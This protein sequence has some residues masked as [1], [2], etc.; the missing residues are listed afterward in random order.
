[1]DSNFTEVKAKI[2]KI[3]DTSMHLT[4][5]F[6]DEHCANCSSLCNKKD[7]VTKIKKMDGY[8]VG[9]TVV[10]KNTDKDIMMKA[11]VIYFIPVLSILVV[12]MVSKYLLMF[13][14]II[15]AILSLVSVP[16]L[17]II[18]KQVYK[19]RVHIDIRKV[20]ENTVTNCNL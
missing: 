15:S 9:D 12:S 10:I 8:N 4:K 1:M 20:D 18:I 3:D 2:I 11:F 13:P 14:D 19:N 5:V 17:F 7:A 16:I 6:D